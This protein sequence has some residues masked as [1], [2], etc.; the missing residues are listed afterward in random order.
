[1][2]FS[3]IYGCLHYLLLRNK[4]SPNNFYLAHDS[5]NRLGPAVQF[6]WSQLDLL[7]GLSLL[8]FATGFSHISVSVGATGLTRL[9]STWPYL[10]AG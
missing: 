4:P 9:W 2:I 5:V 7:M 3:N 8:V 6:F 1:M 10:P